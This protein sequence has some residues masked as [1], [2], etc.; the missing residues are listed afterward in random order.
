M[1]FNIFFEIVLYFQRFLVAKENW[2]LQQIRLD[3]KDPRHFSICL[4]SVISEPST[5]RHLWQEKSDLL[6]LICNM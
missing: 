1:S 4:L 3:F 6:E 5:N 2:H